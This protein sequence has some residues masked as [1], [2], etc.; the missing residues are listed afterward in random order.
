MSAAVVAT[1]SRPD[2]LSQRVIG[3]DV[4]VFAAASGCN[5]APGGRL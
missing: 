2:V 5:R 1:S 3:Y 4:P